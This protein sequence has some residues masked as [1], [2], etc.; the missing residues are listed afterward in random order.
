MIH[1]W[2]SLASAPMREVLDRLLHTRSRD[3]CE[4]DE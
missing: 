3:A 2:N 1:V 4:G